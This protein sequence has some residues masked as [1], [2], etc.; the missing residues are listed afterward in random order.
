MHLWFIFRLPYKLRSSTLTIL[1]CHS[2][3][4]LCRLL[5]NYTHLPWRYYNVTPS[6]HCVVYLINYT[7]LPWQYYNVT[8]NQHLVVHLIN[9]TH[10][11]TLV[12]YLIN[13][14][15]SST[16]TIL[17]CHSHSTFCRL[18]YKL[19]SATLTVQAICL[20]NHNYPFTL[21]ILPVYR[22]KHMRLHTESYR[23]VFWS[24]PVYFLEPTHVHYTSLL[25]LAVNRGKEN[26]EGKTMDLCI[27]GSMGKTVSGRGWGGVGVHT[28]SCL[29]M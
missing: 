21:R 27:Y 9:Y 8:P 20:L 26:D 6:Q 29:V 13:Y 22:L 23:S 3:S 18:P 12:V 24:L 2:Q 15:R 16:L 25:L 4:T 1:Q 14:T 19:H 28:W 10:L 7:Q 5:I 11:S 17:Q